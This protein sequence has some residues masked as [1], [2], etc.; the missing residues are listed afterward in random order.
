MC[1]TRR[2]WHHGDRYG[3]KLSCVSALIDRPID[4]QLTQG[5]LLQKQK[6]GVEE[7]DV[8]RQIVQLTII[9]K[10]SGVPLQGC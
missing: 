4:P 2:P 3:G 9:E 6:D 8:L 10:V 5:F 1:N 7:L